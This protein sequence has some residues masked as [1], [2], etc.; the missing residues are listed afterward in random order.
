M[1]SDK[2]VDFLRLAL[3]DEI[4][5]ALSYVRAL[6]IR[7]F[8]TTSKYSAPNLDME[9]AGREMRVT[10]IITGHYLKEGDQLQITLEAVDVANNRTVWRDTLN[11]GA[12]DMIALRREIAAKVHQGLVPALGA[13]DSSAEAGTRPKNEEA[14][15]LYLR[16]VSLAHDAAP[17][18]EAISML[19]RSA[20]LDATYAPTWR[21]LG[22]RYYYDSHYSGGG[23]AMFERSITVLERALA[24]DPDYSDAA[25]QLITNRVERADLGKAYQDAKALVAR[26]PEKRWR[27]LP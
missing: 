10:D 20:G 2:D 16:S 27:I 8:A 9:Q 23:E 25:G 15:D 24:L 11:V 17:N 12:A 4:A 5:T 21:A 6:S 26:H 14:Y 22:E 3:P 19:E 7:P 1:S 18:R 13:G